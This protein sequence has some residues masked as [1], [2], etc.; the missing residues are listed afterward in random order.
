MR[1]IISDS[2][3]PELSRTQ[4]L[5]FHVVGSGEEIGH[6]NGL[7][8]TSILHTIVLSQMLKDQHFAE[9]VPLKMG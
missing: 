2:A 4:P 6:E 7:S 8:C 1:Y 3:Y 9:E 5:F